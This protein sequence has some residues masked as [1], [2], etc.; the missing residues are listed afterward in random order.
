[1]ARVQEE[2]A[3][4][5]ERGSSSLTRVHYNAARDLTVDPIPLNRKYDPQT[6]LTLIPQDSA[7]GTFLVTIPQK[8]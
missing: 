8:R 6:D 3:A 7:G 1:M 4:Y 2:T 5:V